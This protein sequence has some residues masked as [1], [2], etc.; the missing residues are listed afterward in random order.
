ME[1]RVEKFTAPIFMKVFL[2]H[3]SCLRAPVSNFMNIQKTYIVH[4]AHY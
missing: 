1:G 3:M 4:S 2:G